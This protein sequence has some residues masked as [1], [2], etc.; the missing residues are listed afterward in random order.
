ML[1]ERWTRLH[2]SFFHIRYRQ[3]VPTLYF[4]TTLPLLVVATPCSSFY[5]VRTEQARAIR[6]HEHFLGQ[7][8]SIVDS[9]TTLAYYY[10]WLPAST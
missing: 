4:L 3:N 7:R 10:Y 8:V 6:L 1:R 9:F 5:R 2:Q